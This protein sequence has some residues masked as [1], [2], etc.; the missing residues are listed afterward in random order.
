MCAVGVSVEITSYGHYGAEES[1]GK[2]TQTATESKT[3]PAELTDLL[4]KHAAALYCT[5]TTEN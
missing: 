5:V 4:H 1:E 3:G 2:L